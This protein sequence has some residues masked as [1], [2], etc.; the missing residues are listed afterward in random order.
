MYDVFQLLK[1]CQKFIS[2]STFKGIIIFCF[3][4]LINFKVDALPVC[5]NVFVNNARESRQIIENILKKKRTHFD[6]NEFQLLINIAHLLMEKFPISEYEYIGVGR[7]P[8]PIVALLEALIGF[9]VKQLP[10][11]SF[12]HHSNKNMMTLVAGMYFEFQNR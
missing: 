9:E 2:I 11:T 3:L 1:F 4:L 8:T 12:R 10:L 7:S 5:E 6:E